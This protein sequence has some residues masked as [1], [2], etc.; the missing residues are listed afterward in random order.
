MWPHGGPGEPLQQANNLISKRQTLRKKPEN[1]K[2]LNDAADTL[3]RWGRALMKRQTLFP[4][5][6]LEQFIWKPTPEAKNA[7]EVL[8]GVRKTLRALRD[9]KAAKGH[10]L[11]N[12]K[13]IEDMIKLADKRMKAI[14]VAKGVQSGAATPSKASTTA[15]PAAPV[16]P[17]PG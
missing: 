14:A 1:A 10:A 11:D 17:V 2:L 4:D 16:A 15:A 8:D 3:L 13:E 12:S 9:G 5:H 6:E 7:E